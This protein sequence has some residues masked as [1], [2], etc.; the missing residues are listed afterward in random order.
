[1][2]GDGRAGSLVGARYLAQLRGRERRC[3]RLRRRRGRRCGRLSDGRD[4]GSGLQRRDGCGCGGLS[5]RRSGRRGAGGRRRCRRGAAGELLLEPSEAGLQ[6]AERRID[7]GVGGLHQRELEHRALVGAVAGGGHR[8]GEQLQQ[9]GGLVAPDAAGLIVEQPVAVGGEPHLRRD[10]AED[11][12]DEQVAR[13]ALDLAGV[14]PEV[15]AVRGDV[16]HH[17]ERVRRAPGDDGV[18]G[19]EDLGVVTDAEHGDGVLLGDRRAR[20]GDELL[21][22]AER[23]AER[24]VGVAGNETDGA[25]AHGQPLA[26]GD[27]REHAA[28]LLAGRP[29]EV[30]AV[31]A[32]DDGRRH[33]VRLGGGEH[34]DGL[35]RR[36]LERLQERVPCLRREHVRLIEDVDAPATAGRGRGNALAQLADV[37][38]RVVR[39]GVHLDHVERGGALDREA[40]LALP[41]GRDGRAVLAV[42]AGGEDLRERR[43][44]GAA[45]TD[46]QVGVVHLALRDGVAERADDVVLADDVVEGTRAVTAVER[47]GGHGRPS[48]GE[49]RAGGT[50]AGSVTSTHSPHV[51]AA[52]YLPAFFT[53]VPTSK[54]KFTLLPSTFLAVSFTSTW[55]PLGA[56]STH[57]CVAPTSAFRPSSGHS[58]DFGA[59]PT[60]SLSLE[61]TVFSSSSDGTEPVPQAASTSVIGRAMGRS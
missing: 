57:V 6:R 1:M 41:A 42:Q 8:L 47:R 38:D 23:V 16:L 45:R 20:I 2:V 48:L 11:A 22:R 10:A 19:T 43:L 46:E 34:E 18:D 37:V 13:M 53:S 12:A 35:R 17:A 27:A 9:A 33:L 51:A 29:G 26:L 58:T 32:I 3:G 31:A 36:L 21:E 30:E 15:A 55:S 24:A 4:R 39:G 25:G 50:R 52:G 28:D 44:A 7:G 61:V 49:P 14:G 5:G 54:S 40:A 59:M 60:W 56:V